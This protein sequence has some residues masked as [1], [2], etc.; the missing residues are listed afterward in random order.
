MKLRF[1]FT[2]T[3]NSIVSTNEIDVPISDNAVYDMFTPGDQS[4]NVRQVIAEQGFYS[5][6][7]WVWGV[8]NTQTEPG[9]LVG[10]SLQ[11][12]GTFIQVRW[13]HISY[14]SDGTNTI[15][16]MF[17]HRSSDDAIVGMQW[18]TDKLI[19]VSGLSSTYDIFYNFEL[20]RKRQ[21]A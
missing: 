12:G 1:D 14:A 16:S 7:I 15:V 4:T 3:D 2:K 13:A 10:V 6:N 20:F 9:P 21:D 19:M 11:I 18:K 17:C 8:S 5:A